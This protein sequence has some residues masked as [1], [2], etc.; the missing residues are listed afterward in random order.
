MSSIISSFSSV[1][2]ESD[3]IISGVGGH[4]PGE[5]TVGG[6]VRG[7]EVVGRGNDIGELLEG[8]RVVRLSMIIFR[9]LHKAKNLR[10]IK[11][12]GEFI[13]KWTPWRN[14][15]VIVVHIGKMTPTPR[16][17][18]TLRVLT[19]SLRAYIFCLKE[20]KINIKE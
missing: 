10:A 9:Q 14:V 5:S 1:N 16:K 19:L 3:R 20:N 13:V 6:R 12:T 4:L 2:G 7:T 8:D 18:E 11:T 15:W 17:L